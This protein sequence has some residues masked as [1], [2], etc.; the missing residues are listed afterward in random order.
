MPLYGL[1]LLYKKLIKKQIMKD[2]ENLWLSLET[3][4]IL[5]EK[6]YLTPSEI[7]KKTIP[8]MLNKTSDIIWQSQTWTGKTAAFGL[9]I[10]ENLLK[11]NNNFDK[12]IKAIILSP[13]R[14]LAIQI[15]NE[16][17]SFIWKRPLNVFTIYGWQ[18]YILERNAL[19][20]WIDILIWT[21]WRIIDHLNNWYIK[22]DNIQYFVL[23]EADEMLNMWFI[24]DIKSVLERC[25][26]QKTT[27]FF[28]A[29]MPADILRVAKT[30]MKDYQIVTV[31]TAQLT[32]DFTDQYYYTIKQ[33][34]K[35]ELLS[36]I[37]DM[38]YDFYGIIFCRTKKDVDELVSLLANKWYN[39]DSIHWDISQAQREKTIKKFKTGHCKILVATDV[40]ARW[41]DVKNL[42]HVIN[43]SLPQ[44]S[45]DYTHRIWR[46]WRAGQKWI[47]I[48]FVWPYEVK[49]VE[50]IVYTT[51]AK[52]TQKPIPSVEEVIA[53]QSEKFRKM[54]AEKVSS[55]DYKSMVPMAQELLKTENAETILAAILSSL[56]QDKFSASKYGTI[57]E[58]WGRRT[59]EWSRE[60]WRDSFRDSPREYSRDSSREWSREYG[61]DRFDRW[62]K[63]PSDGSSSRLFVAMWKSKWMNPRKLVDFI[64]QKTGIQS[65]N[66]DD[67]QVLENF[68]FFST[69]KELATK[70]VTAFK[71]NNRDDKPLITLAK[72][73]K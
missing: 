19:R 34:D 59:R 67:V 8:L 2:F 28:S 5:K 20:K 64:Y 73:E 65:R 38:E 71:T 41:L 25:P 66:I 48:T 69:K 70:I 47:A 56:L 63:E 27:L 45:Q 72:Y 24:D 57:S 37:I 11:S 36:R 68:S 52:I 18:S 32:S 30:Y 26:D 46:T 50:Q 14:E 40:A 58:I 16:I 53:F 17:K 61:R 35:L 62:S 49:K 1:F 15:W 29:T 9:P 55:E 44:N 12:N 6:W 60:W 43:Y 42:S 3:L 54:I 21:P 10:I 51:K 33:T 23:D 22:L 39:V 7:Q 13:T 4:E 31:K